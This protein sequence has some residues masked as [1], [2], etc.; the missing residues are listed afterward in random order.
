MIAEIRTASEIT[1]VEGWAS[2]TPDERANLSDLF[3]MVMAAKESVGISRVYVTSWKRG[4]GAHAANGSALDFAGTDRESTLRMWLYIAQ[5]M[6]ARLGE[7]IYEQPKTGVT[8]HVH[9]TLPG[10]GGMGQI[11]Y[12][13]D[14]GGFIELDPFLCRFFGSDFDSG[15]DGDSQ[16]GPIADASVDIRIGGERYTGMV[17]LDRG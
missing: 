6:R 3:T 1:K 14:D 13:K 7:A 9:L 16:P 8:G 15:P 2:A 12:Q 17:S 5:N 11:L 4:S 10:I